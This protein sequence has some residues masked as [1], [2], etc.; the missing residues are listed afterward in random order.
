M[1]IILVV[2]TFVCYRKRRSKAAGGSHHGITKL[3]ELGDTSHQMIMQLEA[4]ESKAEMSTNS[5]H[6]LPQLET[7]ETP[8]E[9]PAGY[10][11]HHEIG[12]AF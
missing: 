1:L 6:E 8:V 10:I 4:I 2:A 12:R 7:K 11:F 5:Q 9:L 3:G